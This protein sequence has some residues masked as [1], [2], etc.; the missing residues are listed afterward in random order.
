MSRTK[1]GLSVGPLDLYRKTYIGE[2]NF[3]LF[4]FLKMQSQE[5]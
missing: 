1:F 5:L 4:F 3:S 2:T